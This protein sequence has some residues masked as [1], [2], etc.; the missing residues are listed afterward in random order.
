MT[1]AEAA[2]L[3]R[4]KKLVKRAGWHIGVVI[5]IDSPPDDDSYKEWARED[6]QIIYRLGLT[7]N[8]WKGS[9]VERV[10]FMKFQKLNVPENTDLFINDEGKPQAMEGKHYAGSDEALKSF[11]EHFH[12]MHF[13]IFFKDKIELRRT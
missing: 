2:E 6:N 12:K 5:M 3:S 10:G 9:E 11:N 8:N 1:Y 13:D 4:N 7:C